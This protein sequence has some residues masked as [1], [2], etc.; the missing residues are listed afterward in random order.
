MNTPSSWFPAKLLFNLLS[1][2]LLSLHRGV[3]FVNY[4]D[5]DEAVRAI[6]QLNG[7]RIGVGRQLQVALQAPRAVRAAAAANA[8]AV[9]G[10]QL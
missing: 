4:R 8:S 1:L 2:N 6:Q 7:T 3:G 5:H 10:G 9:V